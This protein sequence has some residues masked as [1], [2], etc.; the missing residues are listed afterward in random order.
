M[1]GLMR[2]T[3]SRF[4]SPNAKQSEQKME[5]GTVKWAEMDAGI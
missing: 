5:S 2:F 3:L 1:N 4:P